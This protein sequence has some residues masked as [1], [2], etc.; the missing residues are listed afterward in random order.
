MLEHLEKNDPDKHSAFKQ[1]RAERTRKAKEAESATTNIIVNRSGMHVS[2]E[3]L[4]TNTLSSSLFQSTSPAS[5]TKV[6][7]GGPAVDD[8][9]D[10][11]MPEEEETAIPPPPPPRQLPPPLPPPNR[12]P[13]GFML[14]RG[15]TPVSAS[16]PPGFRTPQVG[17]GSSLPLGFQPLSMVSQSKSQSGV[18]PVSSRPFASATSTHNIDGA[19]AVYDPDF[20][21]S[22]GAPPPP[23]P[24]PAVAKKN[25]TVSAAPQI[26]DKVAELK[27][28]IPTSVRVKRNDAANSNVKSP[29]IKA[30]AVAP[31]VEM[32][33][34]IIAAKTTAFDNFMSEMA[35]L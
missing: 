34:S 28:F 17:L 22:L 27:R 1:W 31:P 33:E 13:P 23:P 3:Q 21:G 14:P 12:L 24:K 11:P 30:M 19:P 5:L 32:P 20:A 25:P 29:A 16:L 15:P 18:Y 2:A 9:D 10:I 7:E 6:V 26:R 4:Q 35:S 8:L